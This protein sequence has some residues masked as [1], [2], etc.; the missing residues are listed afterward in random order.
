MVRKIAPSC[1]LCAVMALLTACGA[2]DVPTVP[3]STR[4]TPPAP[5]TGVVQ[6]AVRLEAYSG[7][8]FSPE[9]PLSGA[10][11]LVTE[12]PGAGQSVITGA[13][14]AYGLELPPGPFRLRWS[15]QGA[16]SRDSD[17]GAVTAGAT[18]IVNTVVL[19]RSFE[20]NPEWS[21]GGT[22]RDSRGNPVAGVGVQT[23]DGV[24]WFVGYTSTD[25]TGRFGIA[26]KRPHPDWLHISVYKE[27]Y[28]G[29]NIT[30]FCGP[31]CTLTVDFRLEAHVRE[32]L[33]GPSTMQVGNVATV[34]LVGEYAD[35]TRSVERAEIISSND[36]ALQVVPWPASPPPYDRTYVKAIAPGTATL[37]QF[38]GSQVLTLNVQVFP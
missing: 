34:S 2:A 8:V 37:K 30:L 11:V 33:D 16:E 5:L 15:A 19:K 18:T 13:N 14:G 22:V 17:P 28:P 23:W 12:G 25:A 27:G 29:Q 10:Q 24:A 20:G 21:V 36:G 3:S 4:V 32:W 6:G 9:A 38:R 7:L 35:G 26:S 1:A 31:S